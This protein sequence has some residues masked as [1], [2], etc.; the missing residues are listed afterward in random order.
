M[1]N[2]NKKRSYDGKN[3]DLGFQIT[4]ISQKKGKIKKLKY[5][6]NVDICNYL[7]LEN[8]F[9]FYSERVDN[10]KQMISDFTYFKNEFNTL[11]LPPL[12]IK[13]NTDFIFCHV[14]LDEIFNYRFLKFNFTLLSNELCFHDYIGNMDCYSSKIISSNNGYEFYINNKKRDFNNLKEAFM[15]YLKKEK[16][17]SDSYSL[18]NVVLLT[19]RIDNIVVKY[20]GKNTLSNN[21]IK[22][23]KLLLNL[24]GVYLS[25]RGNFLFLAKNCINFVDE[26]QK[27]IPTLENSYDLLKQYIMINKY[28][29]EKYNN[30]LA[31]SR[32]SRQIKKEFLEICFLKKLKIIC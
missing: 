13:K 19:D 6:R 8:C 31:F 25:N 2:Y 28:L 11:Y 30:Y 15:F 32:T 16:M 4:Y 9:N 10:Y 12:I 22:N 24:Y 23:N 18:D 20:L 3:S 1:K 17:N 7:M 21:L 5:S 14:K 27:L 26:Y 29:C